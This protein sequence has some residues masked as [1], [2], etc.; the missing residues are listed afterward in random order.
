MIRIRSTVTPSDRPA[1]IDWCRALG[2]SRLN[3]DE[4]GKWA[5]IKAAWAAN[6]SSQ[7]SWMRRMDGVTLA[8][9]NNLKP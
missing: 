3:R 4:P 7:S 8:Q 9:L 1:Y 5:G 2:V 6:C